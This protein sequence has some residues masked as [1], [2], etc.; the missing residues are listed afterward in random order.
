M[1]LISVVLAVTTLQ[2]RAALKGSASHSSV[3][4]RTALTL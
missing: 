3:L 1:C 4:R 2:M